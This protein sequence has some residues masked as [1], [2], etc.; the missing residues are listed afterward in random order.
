MSSG[1]GLAIADLPV[2]LTIVDP[3][4]A[5]DV[6]A[7]FAP[8]A[9]HDGPYLAEIEVSG[10]APARPVR[11]PDEVYGELSLWRDG[12]ELIVESGGLLRGHVSATR[13]VIGG[14]AIDG[15]FA[16]AML[17]AVLHHVLSQL[18]SLS[19]RLVAHAAAVGQG[20]KAVLLL[21]E[22]GRGKSTSAY[23]ASLAGW[24][25]LSDDLVA[26][27][28]AASGV[29]VLGVH[30]AVAVPPE[31]VTADATDIGFDAR[32]RRRPDVRL[33]AGAHEV[34]AVA[35][36]DHGTG[37]GELVR[38]SAMT[39]ARAVLGSTPAGGHLGVAADALTMAGALAKLPAY[40]F[41]LP[42]TAGRRL[43][44]VPEWLDE[45]IRA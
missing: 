15:P 41:C 30:R 26:L 31:L 44:R 43:A 33:E 12:D 22:S 35:I 39:V 40:R 23:I 34:V 36:I 14:P 3:A 4:L 24:A 25:L 2:R 20:G 10:A 19:G 45:V 6:L 8:M 16:A 9:D 28:F 29:E 42:D 37:E 27:R 17:R 21:G 18:L 13:A 5:E 32:A 11:E 38:E 7:L 1:R